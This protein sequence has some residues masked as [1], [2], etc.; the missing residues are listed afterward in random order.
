MDESSF[1]RWLIE[2]IWVPAYAALAELFRQLL[3]IRS[4]L[5]R[6]TREEKDRLRM[7]EAN[8]TAIR[9]IESGIHGLGERLANIEGYLDGRERQS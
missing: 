2:W 8:T 1:F 9:N 3:N 4:A 6:T 7:E 5:K